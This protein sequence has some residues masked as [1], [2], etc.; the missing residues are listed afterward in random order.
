MGKR[1]IKVANIIEDGRLAGPQMRIIEIARYLA[2]KEFANKGKVFNS[3]NVTTDRIKINT[4]VFFP[5]FENIEFKNLLMKNKINFIELPIHR[6]SKRVANF[7][8][9]FFFFFI[10]ICILWFYL[11]KGN[12]DIVHISGGAW[13]FK[14]IIAGK[15]AKCKI[16][17]HLNDTK[18]P[19]IIYIL[20]RLLANI[21]TDGFI[22][23]GYR[24]YKYYLERY[25]KLKS[26][27]IFLIRPPVNCFY[28]NSKHL[29]D[30]KPNYGL[31]ILTVGNVNPN[32]GFEY[33]LTMAHILNSKYNNLN[34]FIVGPIYKSQFA[35]YKKLKQLQIKYNLSNLVFYGVC[36]DIRKVLTLTDIFVCSS[37]NESGPMSVWEAMAMEKAIV[38]TDVGDIPWLLKN[39]H[40]GYIVPKKNPLELAKH[41]SILIDDN[42]KRIEFGK[43]ARQIAIEK[44]D[45]SKIAEN[46]LKSY[47][48]IAEK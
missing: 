37:I 36:K 34:F 14:G 30:H 10:E 29:K 16:I 18:A 41:V 21:T 23:S 12:Y 20:F 3:V 35:Y 13:Q 11:K 46:H 19:R 38:T 17:W 2:N 44:L 27:K 42:S 32:K 45:V 40:N 24:V 15:L 31:N 5:I 25:L 4:T 6:L 47:L 43:K 8:S 33:F 9:F 26:K 1:I 7:L 28:F 48:S 39:N 22:V